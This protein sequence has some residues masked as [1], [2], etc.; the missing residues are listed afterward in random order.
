M[1]TPCPMKQIVLEDTSF[2]FLRL[3]QNELNHMTL[4]RCRQIVY[5]TSFSDECYALTTCTIHGYMSKSPKSKSPK[6]KSPT[7]KSPK[8][9]SPKSKSPKL[10]NKRKFIGKQL[11]LS[12]EVESC[13]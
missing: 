12:L 9:K 11:S 1:Q 2:F 7:P 6:S 4:V 13:S 3:N 8:S 5:K 10:K